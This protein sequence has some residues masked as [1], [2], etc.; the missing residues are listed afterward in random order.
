[1]PSPLVS[2]IPAAAMAHQARAGLTGLQ[3]LIGLMVRAAR[4]VLA[5]LMVRVTRQVLAGLMVQMDPVVLTVPTGLVVL[6]ALAPVK[7]LVE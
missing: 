3:V 4:Q 2:L 7:N 6:A 1:M 5:G